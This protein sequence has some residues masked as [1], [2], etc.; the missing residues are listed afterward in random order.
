MNELVE[1]DAVELRGAICNV[2]GITLRWENE[3]D[4]KRREWRGRQRKGKGGKAWDRVGSREE[5]H[6]VVRLEG[7]TWCLI[8]ALV[9]VLAFLG[10]VNG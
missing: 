1:G 10:E 6:Y 2:T 3:S 8:S 4:R 9:M 7:E 5:E